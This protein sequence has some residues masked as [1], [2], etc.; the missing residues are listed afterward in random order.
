[1]KR[2]RGDLHISVSGE[3]VVKGAKLRARGRREK[4]LLPLIFMRGNAQVHTS[5]LPPFAHTQLRER[6]RERSTPW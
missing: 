4:L 5:S 1:M 6:E 2:E 3:E